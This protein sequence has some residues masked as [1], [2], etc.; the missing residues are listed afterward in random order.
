M[1]SKFENQTDLNILASGQEGIWNPN[2]IQI[3]QDATLYLIRGRKNENFKYSL[4]KNR[5]IYCVISTCFGDKLDFS[6]CT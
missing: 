5:Q 4:N 2:L 6:L 1:N 3:Y